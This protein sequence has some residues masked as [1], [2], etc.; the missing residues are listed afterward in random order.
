MAARLEQL[1]KEYG[2][3]VLVSGDTV[4]TLEDSYPLTLIGEVSLRGKA[5]PVKVYKL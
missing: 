5:A 3:S 4:A 2:T 1:N